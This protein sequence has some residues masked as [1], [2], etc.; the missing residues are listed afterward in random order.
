MH[1][2]QIN[3]INII[4]L[5]NLRVFLIWNWSTSSS[6]PSD[7]H[8]LGSTF[9]LCSIRRRHSDLT[10]SSLFNT[11]SRPASVK[12]NMNLF[13]TCP[14]GSYPIKSSSG[15]YAYKSEMCVNIRNLKTL[16]WFKYKNNDSLLLCTWIIMQVHHI[17]HRCT[18]RLLLFVKSIKFHYLPHL[19]TIR[20]CSETS[21]RHRSSR[22]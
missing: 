1:S 8:F 14:K 13:A 4:Q 3:Q 19:Y 15:L 16:V 17:K 5:T 20:K 7:S 9:L 6:L 18:E 2:R 12:H 21:I 11:S 22:D 10:F